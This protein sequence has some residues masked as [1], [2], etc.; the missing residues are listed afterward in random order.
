MTPAIPPPA[1]E[2]HRFGCRVCG[3]VHLSMSFAIVPPTVRA[4]RTTIRSHGT[5]G[6]MVE[7]ECP[8]HEDPRQ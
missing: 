6:V 1:H 3:A 8:G 4:I 7:Y 2:S 5:L